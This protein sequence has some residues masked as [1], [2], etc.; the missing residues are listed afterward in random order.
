[1]P[2]VHLFSNEPM[3]CN[4][5]LSSKEI[6]GMPFFDVL[7]ES[8]PATSSIAANCGDPNLGTMYAKNVVREA[9][10]CGGTPIEL[11]FFRE[12]FPAMDQKQMIDT[13]RWFNHY[14]CDPDFNIWAAA[15]ATGSAPGQ[16][17]WFTL[18][19]SNHGGNGTFSNAVPGYIFMDKDNQVPYT[20]TDVDTTIPYAHRIQV[21]PHDATVTVDIKPNKAYLILPAVMIGGCSCPLLTNK[22][23]SIGYSQV[24]H[25][26]RVRNDWKMCVDLLKGYRDRVQFAVIYDSQGNPVDSWDVLEARQGREGLQMALNILA[27]LGTPITNPQLINGFDNGTNTIGIDGDYTGFYGL[28]PTL[29]Y[30]GGR[31]YNYRSDLGFDLEADGEPIF[32]FQDSRKRTKKFMVWHGAKFGMSLVDRTNKLVPKTQV[33]SNMWQAFT[34]LGD[35]TGNDFMTEVAKYGIRSYDYMGFHLDFKKQDSFSDYRFLGSDYFNS[36]AVMFAED[37]ISENGRPLQPVEFYNIGKGKWTGDYEEYF[38]D[39]RKIDGCDNIGGWMA[40]TLAM[41]VHCP[42]QHILINPVKAA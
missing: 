32:L 20:I 9:I 36:M 18:A 13:K 26:L 1:M 14:M 7:A 4:K 31:V 17:F 38:I 12:M 8:D 40:E 41:A 28:L 24:V 27:F 37:G 39:Y 16:P 34:R 5:P 21:V 23:N 29:K 42:D 6:L 15:R 33:G 11:N 22:M 10:R 3:F 35:L 2:D 25:P 30:G 19:K